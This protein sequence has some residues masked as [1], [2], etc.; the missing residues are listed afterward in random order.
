MLN[1]PKLYSEVIPQ[2]DLVE[3]YQWQKYRNS[4][5]INLIQI[6]IY[7]PQRRRGRREWVFCLSRDDDKQK[8]VS[9]GTSRFCLI[10]NIPRGYV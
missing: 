4:V 9:I 1:V 8:Q 7:S 3:Y 10:V 6:L 2:G 5:A